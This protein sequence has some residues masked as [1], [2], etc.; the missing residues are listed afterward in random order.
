MRLAR[1]TQCLSSVTRF[2][3]NLRVWVRLKK[4]TRSLPHNTAIVC[5][6]DVN[7][8]LALLI[9]S[10]ERVQGQSMRPKSP[11]DRMRKSR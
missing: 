2:A 7:R 3:D 8:H 9:L 10:D 5:N 1:Q 11:F 4:P 6:Q